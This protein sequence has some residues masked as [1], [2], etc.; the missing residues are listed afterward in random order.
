MR[1]PRTFPNNT[2]SS[3]RSA[4]DCPCKKFWCF[5]SSANK[6]HKMLLCFT[7]SFLFFSSFRVVFHSGP[8]TYT[9]LYFRSKADSCSWGH[10]TYTMRALPYVGLPISGGCSPLRHHGSC[11]SESPSTAR[12]RRTPPIGRGG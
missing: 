9:L 12:A 2:I 3:W 7:F 5:H 8:H 1:F 11:V 6:K 4:I 10:P